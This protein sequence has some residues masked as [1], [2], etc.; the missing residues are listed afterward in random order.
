VQNILKVA[1]LL[2]ILIWKQIASSI[3]RKIN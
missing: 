2:N 3:L 1:I